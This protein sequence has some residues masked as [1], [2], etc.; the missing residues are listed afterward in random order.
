MI[1][2]LECDKFHMLRHYWR[3]LY[4][5]TH[6]YIYVYKYI[7]VHI[8]ANTFVFNDSAI[9]KSEILATFSSNICNFYSI[10]ILATL[11]KRPEED[12]LF[13]WSSKY[14]TIDVLKYFPR[15]AEIR[16]FNTFG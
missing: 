16:F 3:P 9:R 4:I 5:Y 6:I 10:K 8:Y 15:L 13:L 14:C 11:E 7:C 1:I 12:V 2:N